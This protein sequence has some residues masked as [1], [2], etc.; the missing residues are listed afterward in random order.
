MEETE[1]HNLYTLFARINDG[2]KRKQGLGFGGRTSSP[3]RNGPAAAPQGFLSSFVRSSTTF[4]SETSRRPVTAYEPLHDDSDDEI[5]AKR[6]RQHRVE[7]EDDLSVRAAGRPRW[8][9]SDHGESLGNHGVRRQQHEDEDGRSRFTRAGFAADTSFPERSNGRDDGGRVTVTSP[10]AGAKGMDRTAYAK[11]IPGYDSLGPAERLRARTR[12]ALKQADARARSD[13][14]DAADRGGGSGGNGS[15]TWTRFILNKDAPLDEDG[16]RPGLSAWDPSGIDAAEEKCYNSHGLQDGQENLEI[17]GLNA[18]SFRRTMDVERRQQALRQAEAQHEAAIFGAVVSEA[19]AAAAVAGVSR[20]Q[21]R[22]KTVQQAGDD[23]S[24]DR[25]LGKH[26][27]RSQE[28]GRE[29]GLHRERERKRDR[30]RERGR[31][32]DREGFKDQG[33]ECGRERIRERDRGR[34]CEQDRSR[35]RD[36]DRGQERGRERERKSSRDRDRDRDRE[37]ERIRERGGERERGRERGSDR[38]RDRER[39]LERDRPR[40][41]DPDRD[42]RAMDRPPGR[43]LQVRDRSRDVGDRHQQCGPRTTSKL[44]DSEVTLESSL[45]APFSGAAATGVRPAAPARLAF[46]S[47]TGSRV[48]GDFTVGA[49][50]IG[51]AGSGGAA[52]T[53]AAADLP[54][55]AGNINLRG[56]LGIREAD[57]DGPVVVELDERGVMAAA[58]AAAGNGEGGDWSVRSGWMAAGAGAQPAQAAETVVKQDGGRLGETLSSSVLK[59]QGLS[60]RERAQQARGRAVK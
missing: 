34:D 24:G 12:L 40:D 7:D 31:D 47:T 45:A 42:S 46:V 28:H 55:P 33:R 36:R 43:T 5:P 17:G 53:A 59:Q 13:G 20:Q 37:R 52:A 6:R 22:G 41:K 8:P 11:L 38:E 51:A 57:E 49:S 10:A 15:R 4:G 44:V 3:E 39:G 21:L 27:H 48:D 50:N 60:W 18:L 25:V 58:Q 30:E 56:L 23:T 9:L 35:D 1:A 14:N 2:A 29:G 32:Q 54:M 16:A 26:Y 19:P